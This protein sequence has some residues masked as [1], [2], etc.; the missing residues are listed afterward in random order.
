[1]KI[2]YV[3]W[4]R[5]DSKVSMEKENHKYLENYES[6]PFHKQINRRVVLLVI[7]SEMFRTF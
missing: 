2:W 1:M 4:A 7:V 5:K 6:L 3:F